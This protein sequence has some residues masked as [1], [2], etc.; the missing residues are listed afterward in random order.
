[1]RGSAPEK[2]LRNRIRSDASRKRVV[3]KFLPGFAHLPEAMRIRCSPPVS[4]QCSQELLLTG[5]RLPH[6]ADRAVKRL[7]KK[8]LVLRML[9]V[10]STFVLLTSCGFWGGKSTS[11]KPPV[12]PSSVDVASAQDGVQLSWNCTPDVTKYTVFWGFESG[13]Y[14]GLVDAE[15]CAL[16]LSGLKKGELYYFAATA[17]NKN[18][19]SNYSS[20]KAFVYDDDPARAGHYAAKGHELVLA[21]DFLDAQA[22]LSAAIRLNPQQPDAY[23]SRAVLHERLSRSDLARQ[24]RQQAEK[25]LKNKLVFK[26]GSSS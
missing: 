1:L 17:W 7:A 20:E 19:E 13:E 2:P 25:L 14:R 12:P 9:S 21:G 26:N 10:L 15:D 23:L 6:H 4:P 22:Y 24:D 8:T 16:I 11:R 18:G 5:E 3:P